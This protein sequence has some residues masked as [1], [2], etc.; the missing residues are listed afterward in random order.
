MIDKDDD[1]ENWADPGVPSVG[2][3]PAGRGNDNDKGEG[4]EDT[5]GGEKGTGKGKGTKEGNGKGKGKGKGTVKGKRI[6][7]RTPG[8]DDISRAVALL[9]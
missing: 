3:S 6:V 7:K 2:R 5:Q 1:D 9:L 4:Q 8:E